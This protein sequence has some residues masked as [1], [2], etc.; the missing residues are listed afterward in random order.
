[1][2]AKRS[3]LVESTESLTFG[4]HVIRFNRWLK[5]AR[6]GLPEKVG[7]LNPFS[8]PAVFKLSESFY[9]T[10]Y[11]DYRPRHYLFGINP[12]RLGAGLTG[13][14]FTDPL[15]L[16]KY[17]GIANE[18]S[19]QPELS[20]EFVYR[21]IESMGGPGLFYKDF[22]ITSIC[23][24]GFVRDGINL[25]YYDD[26]DLQ[27]QVAPFIVNSLKKQLKFGCSAKTAFILG[28]GKNMDFIE[29][30]NREHAFFERLIP[31]PHPRFVMQY[32]R[33]H[34]EKYLKTYRDQLSV[35]LES[36]R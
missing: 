1:M 12:G 5:R 32:K 34:L 20:S 18:L 11:A 7:L 23:P 15:N 25:N 28:E 6:P 27:K 19:K 26:K 22:F 17:C 14:P 16:E 29:K 13:I 4:D 35:V 30:L 8:D 3:R 24:L 2:A 9:H 31:L 21:L 33:K 10:Y 36:S